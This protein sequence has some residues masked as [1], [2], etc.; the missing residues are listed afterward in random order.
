M[1][2]RKTRRKIRNWALGLFFPPILRMWAGTLRLRVI[3]DV[4]TENG[5]IRIPDGIALVWHQR[6]FT[7]ASSFPNSN[8]SA[9]ISQHADGEMLARVFQGIGLNP[10]RGST[11]RGGVQAIRELLNTGEGPVRIAITPDGPRGPARE[12]QQGAIYLA[13]KTGLPIYTVAIGLHGK[14]QLRTWD[15]F[16]IPKPFTRALL[17]TGE[18]FQ[19][20]PDLDRE[21]IEKWR[22][23]V[24]AEMR[25]L[26]EDTDERFDELYG[27]GK[28]FR[29]FVKG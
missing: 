18:T 9:L 3:S 2:N 17:R 8:F 15:Q 6:L 7:L 27:E 28:K 23:E 1:L 16:M 24:E 14:W 20:P 10:I 29:G 13:S 22:L 25:R 4:E 12:L 26:T 19:I 21:G 11:T 5:R